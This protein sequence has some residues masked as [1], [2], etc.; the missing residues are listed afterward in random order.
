MGGDSRL[1]HVRH[2]SAKLG[3]PLHLPL[4]HRVVGVK[5]KSVRHGEGGNG[6]GDSNEEGV[7]VGNEDDGTLVGDSLL[8]AVREGSNGRKGSPLLQVEGGIT[9]GEEAVSLGVRAGAHDNP[10]KHGVATVPDFGLDG[11]TPAPSGEFGVFLSKVLHSIIEDGASNAG[12]GP[13]NLRRERGRRS[14]RRGGASSKE[15][16]SEGTK[17]SHDEQFIV[18]LRS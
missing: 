1:L 14:K 7:D 10:A 8:S 15:K 13:G 16:G 5:E 3:V 4:I 6:G 9:V 11:R 12:A 2:N 18:R 17:R